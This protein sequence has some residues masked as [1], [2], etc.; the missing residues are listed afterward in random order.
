MD[1]QKEL[2]LL[3]AYASRINALRKELIK[4]EMRIRQ[5]NKFFQRLSTSGDHVFPR[6]KDLI[7]DISQQFIEDVEGFIQQFFVGDDINQSLFYLREEIKA[8]QGL[9]KILT[10]NTLSFTQTRTRLSGCW[11]KIKK[12]EKERKKE[13]SKQKAIFKEHVEQVLAKLKELQ[14]AFS[15]GALTSEQG[16]DKLDEIMAFMRTQKLGHDEVKALREA[17]SKVRAPIVDKIKTQEQQRHHQE[18]EKDRQ[19]REKI[20]GARARI[21]ELIKNA[22]SLDADR[23]SSSRDAMLEEIQ[24]GLFSKLEKIELEKLLKPLRDIIGDK[25]KKSLLELS[26]GDQQSLSQLKT[27]LAETKER[28]QE[29]KDQLETLLRRVVPLVWILSRR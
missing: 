28:R 1:R 24:T 6:R 9:A 29:I 23:I 13:R 12:L 4:T 14:Q 17:I 22:D 3:N 19:K 16:L 21:E 2:N 26:D 11:D 10:L 5:K 18:Q 20:Q 15:E 27:M 7:K 8:L 25:K